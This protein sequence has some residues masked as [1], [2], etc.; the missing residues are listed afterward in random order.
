MP[1]PTDPG[2]RP[3][4]WKDNAN[5]RNAR[6]R[7]QPDDLIGGFCVTLESETRTPAEGAIQLADFCTEH[8][9]QHVAD[10]HNTWL[11]LYEGAARA[12]AEGE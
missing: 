10:C 3:E 8:V 11:V 2:L 1:D 12:K 4:W 6:W 7:A 5:W 9:A